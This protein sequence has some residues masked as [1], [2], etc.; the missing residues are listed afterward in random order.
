MDI[1][2]L[3]AWS[4]RLAAEW[5]APYF[6]A[7]LRRVAAERAAETVYP[8]SGREFFAL[9]AT[10]PEQVRVVLLGQDP[11]HEPRQ[12]T[13]LAFSVGRGV[14]FPPSLR[15]I[16]TELESDLGIAPPESGDLTGWA[17]QGVLLLNTVLTVRAGQ[18]NSHAAWGWQRFT[19]AVIAATAALPQPVVYLLWGA[20]AQKK[21]ALLTE[22]TAPTCI[23]S[24]PH[25]SPL[26]SYRGY[27][28][29]RP[30]SR[31]NDFLTAHG[32]AA[33]DWGKFDSDRFL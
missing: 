11:Y 26:S 21:A 8:P 30:F 32:S 27:F 20:Q 5:N 25:P 22:R 17:E 3:G 1:S 15:N 23:L 9:T 10:P 24:A 18:A 29:S 12:A 31:A 2:S 16:F 6:Q 14:R 7:L 28:G 4:T 13:G 19:D 33:I